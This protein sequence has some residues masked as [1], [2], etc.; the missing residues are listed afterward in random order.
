MESLSVGSS[1]RIVA[2]T[3]DTC[4]WEGLEARA[5]FSKSHFEKVMSESR[6]V[7]SH[8]GIGSI[9]SA[10]QAQKPIIVVPRRASFGEHR[11]DHQLATA[12]AFEGRCGLRVAWD[13]E[14]IALLIKGEIEMPDINNDP[15]TVPLLDAIRQ[16]VAA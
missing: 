15:A 5:N 6:L 4:S 12:A 10:K 14:S 1:E 13:L 11:N 2:Q 8:A 16:F 9:I 7:I 3:G